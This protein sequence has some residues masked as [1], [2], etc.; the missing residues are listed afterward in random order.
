MHWV[1]QPFKL[2]FSRWPRRNFQRCRGKFNILEGFKML[3]DLLGIERRLELVGSW[4]FWGLV[5]LPW[6]FMGDL[7]GFATFYRYGWVNRRDS[8]MN[9]HV[10]LGIPKGLSS[11][12]FIESM[13]C[14]PVSIRDTPIFIDICPSPSKILGWPPWVSYGERQGL[15]VWNM[16]FVFPYIYIYIY[17]EFVH[18]NWRLIFFRG[19]A[20]TPTRLYKVQRWWCRYTG[21][22][23][24]ILSIPWS[25]SQLNI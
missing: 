18:P 16:I 8:S 25:T 23:K 10:C 20:Q 22:V 19:A 17:W 6:S 13:M 21:M 1:I 7:Y 3:Q 5:I 14:I 12:C 2:R 9:R 4:F 11:H 15:V 24:I